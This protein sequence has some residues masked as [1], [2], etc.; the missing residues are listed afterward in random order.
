MSVPGINDIEI[1]ESLDNYIKAHTRQKGRLVCYETLSSIEQQLPGN[2]F[3]RIHR[4]FIVNVTYVD[5]FTA[6]YIEIGNRKLPIGRIYKEE[7]TRRLS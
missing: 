2:N 3:L 1:I 5:V 7:V 4:S 6:S